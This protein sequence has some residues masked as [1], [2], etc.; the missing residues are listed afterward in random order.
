M[1]RGLLIK[2]SMVLFRQLKLFFILMIGFAII[3]NEATNG[4]ALMYMTMLPITALAFD[5]QSRWGTYAQM[6]PYKIRDIVISKYLI[7][8]IG[9]ALVAVIEIV[10]SAVFMLVREGNLEL[11]TEKL[12]VLL[13]VFCCSLVLMSINLPIIFKMGAE[14]GRILYILITVFLAF[15]VVKSLDTKLWSFEPKIY[16]VAGAV[17]TIAALVISV[18]LSTRFYEKKYQ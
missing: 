10:S 13:L 17:I 16:L 15:G 1:L 11:L 8:M 7:G 5:E 12:L 6:M 2:D 14:R 9:A 18:F 4:F 3:Q